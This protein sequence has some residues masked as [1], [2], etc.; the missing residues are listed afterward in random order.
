MALETR[1]LTAA[2]LARLPDDGFRYELV[3]GELRKMS[4]AGEQHGLIAMRLGWRLAQYVETQKLGIVYAAETGFILSTD[5]DTVR[6]PD[7]AFVRQ[8]RLAARPTGVS[9]RAE[10][11]DLAAEVI[12]PND[13]FAEVEEK[14]IDWL[15][16][17]TQ[18]VLVINPRKRTVTAYRSR[19]DIRILTE[20]E[21]IEGGTVVPG[22]TL[23]VADL[24][25]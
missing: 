25:V 4:P 2:D 22:W 14:V 1:V 10:A 8:E 17:G 24:F 16:A 6:A 5:P 21:Q 11:P 7:V 15:A 12:S 19:T 3:R 9:F 18:L 20:T 23:P 13:V